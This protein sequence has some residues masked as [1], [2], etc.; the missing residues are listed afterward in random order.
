MSA[1]LP[2]CPPSS[3]SPI[4]SQSASLPPLPSRYVLPGRPPCP[5]AFRAA[6]STCRRP[7]SQGQNLA[8]YVPPL[9]DSGYLVVDGLEVGD[10]SFPVKF[11]PR[12]HNVNYGKHL[13]NYQKVADVSKVDVVG[14]W[15][16]SVT[17][18]RE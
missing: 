4:P 16:R 15:Y 17:F 6:A 13:L 8:L 14:P 10:R 5:P 7:E 9:I 12:T 3:L 1:F 18:E 2:P 11:V